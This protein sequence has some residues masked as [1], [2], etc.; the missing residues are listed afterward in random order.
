MD[1][2]S[3]FKG[4]QQHSRLKSDNLASQTYVKVRILRAPQVRVAKKNIRVFDERPDLSIGALAT[5]TR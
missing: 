2:I 5:C 4:L 1:T 3:S